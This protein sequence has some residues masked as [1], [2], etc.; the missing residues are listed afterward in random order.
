MKYNK[1]LLICFSIL[2]LSGCT[3]KYDLTINRDNTITEKISGTVSLEELDNKDRSDLNTY[4]YA[5]DLAT[6]LIEEQGEYNKEIK[7]N[8][9]VKDFVYTYTYKNNYSKANVL[10]KCFENIEYSETDNT[11]TFH[12]YGEFYC[13]LSDE[14]E[15]NLTSN[16]AVTDNNADKVS[17]NKYTWIINKDKN[18]DIKAIVNKNIEAITPTKEKSI[19]TPY[20]I[21][22]VILLIILIIISFVIYKKRNSEN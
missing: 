15:I 18:I 6:P 16:Y 11:Y 5:L 2:L 7:D 21:A 20:Q 19:L 8:E 12:L 13:L 22:T 3:T 17:G 14:I 1:I 9:K 10:N 4:L